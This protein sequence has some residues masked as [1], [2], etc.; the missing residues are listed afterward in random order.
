MEEL[1]HYSTFVYGASFAGIG[2]ALASKKKV[3]VVEPSTMVGREFV[4]SFRVGD[5]WVETEMTTQANEL[6]K[7]LKERALFSEGKV[8]LGPVASVMF[9][10]IHEAQLDVLMRTQ[11]T[12][13]EQREDGTFEIS[14][15]NASGIKKVVADTIIDTTCTGQSLPSTKMKLSAKS[16]NV[17]LHRRPSEGNSQQTS[18]FNPDLDEEVIR[19]RQIIPSENVQAGVQLSRGLYPEELVL[20]YRVNLEDDWI[21]A[22]GKLYAYWE[23]NADKFRPWTMALIADTFEVKPASTIKRIQDHWEWLPSSAYPNLLQAFDTGIRKGSEDFEVIS[24]HG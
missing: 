20:S 17:M 4:S 9:R 10:I 18:I 12:G 11:L 15:F 3:L 13:M 14:L 6:L 1:P 8:H 24:A 22:R 19:L 5:H 21:Q 16:L 23:K 2:I 7:E